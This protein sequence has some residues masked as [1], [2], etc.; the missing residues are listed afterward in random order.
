[1]TDTSN[2]AIATLLAQ[3]AE[4]DRQIAVETLVPLQAAQAVMNRPSTG[5]IADDLE[6][7]RADLPEGEL[8][9]E[10][11]GNV[12]TV[13]RAVQ[14]LIDQEVSRVEAITQPNAAE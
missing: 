1:M 5:K 8:A 9:H 2:S 12:I 3:R 4:L 14:A 11:V 7:L 6:K 13:I 10:Q